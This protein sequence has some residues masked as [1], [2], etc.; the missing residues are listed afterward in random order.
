MDPAPPAFPSGMAR[1]CLGCA[2]WGRGCLNRA[3]QVGAYTTGVLTGWSLLRSRGR[4]CSNTTSS[5]GRRKPLLSNGLVDTLPQHQPHLH[6]ASLSATL[7][8]VRTPVIGFRALLPH[9]SHSEVPGGHEFEG[10]SLTRYTDLHV[11][12]CVDDVHNPTIIPR[13]TVFSPQV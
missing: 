8:L 1:A 11:P 6:V 4:V 3:P 13:D 5:G 2:G 10:L 7:P 12:V 9:K